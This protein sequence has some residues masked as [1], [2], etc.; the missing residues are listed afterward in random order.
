VI[1]FLLRRAL[2]AIP[3]LLVIS[4]LVFALLQAAPGGPLAIYLSNPNVRPEDIERLRRALGLD[5]PL[6]Q[7]YWSWL[8]AFVRGDWGYSYSDGRAV[9]ERI[10]ERL[11]A[12]LELV[13]VALAAALAL[14]LPAGVIA[15]MRRGRAFDRVAGVLSM[16]GISLPAF[17]FGLVLQIAFAVTLGWLPSAGRSTPGAGG[18]A[19][20]LQHLVMPVTVL[21]FVQAASWS[22]YL[23]GSMVEVLTQPF[24]LAARARGV[25]ARRVLLVHALRNAIG[26][27]LAVVMVDAALLVSGAV[28][29][30]SVFAWPGL[31]SLFTEALARRDYTVLMALLMLASFAIVALNVAADAAHAALDA[32]VALT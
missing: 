15:A 18:A 30:E 6:W 23:R 2:Q 11:P 12:T 10:L 7:Q 25:P 22:R 28:V 9:A 17:W 32:R 1:R 14:T 29:T 31:G 20:H 27:V 26:P 13:G 16:A 8:A 4:A 21:A 24:V 19:D 5:R 3:L